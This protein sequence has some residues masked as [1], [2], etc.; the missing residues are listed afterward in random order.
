MRALARSCV[1]ARQCILSVHDS[2][3]DQHKRPCL[4]RCL[5]I[6]MQCAAMNLR[7]QK[8]RYNNM[9]PVK[10]HILSFLVK[11]TQHSPRGT[12]MASQQHNTHAVRPSTSPRHRRVQ[13]FCS[14]ACGTHMCSTNS[15]STAGTQLHEPEPEREH[16]NGEG[17]CKC[18]FACGCTCNLV[19]SSQPGCMSCSRNW[20]TTHLPKKKHLLSC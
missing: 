4:V 11:R 5:T 20:E 9:Q 7:Q 13:Q 19:G 18:A 1:P 2:I 14:S 16:E 8:S 17:M 3:C 6:N 12:V 10:P 15:C